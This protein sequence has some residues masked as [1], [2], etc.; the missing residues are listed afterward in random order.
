MQCVK[1]YILNHTT[2]WW[3]QRNPHRGM[4]LVHLLIVHHDQCILI[5]IKWSDDQQID[6][7]NESNELVSL[8]ISVR[9]YADEDG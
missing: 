1:G 3:L 4:P 2:A 5:Y 7:S 6:R 9:D 8:R